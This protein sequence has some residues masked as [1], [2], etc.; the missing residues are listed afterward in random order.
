M[1]LQTFQSIKEI[2]VIQR[3]KY[4]VNSNKNNYIKQQKGTI[5]QTVATES[6][7]Y[8]IEAVCVCGLIIAVCI[9]AIDSENSAALVPQLASFAVA[10][11]RILP[12]LG[13]ISSYFNQFMFCIPGINDTYNNLKEAR[14]IEEKTNEERGK[15]NSIY[16][17][18]NQDI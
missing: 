12:S 11:F 14:I 1:L 15:S 9:K 17:N 10:A 3:Q 6:P 2:L 16:D 13:R 8:M 7:A 18:L 4:F 5:G